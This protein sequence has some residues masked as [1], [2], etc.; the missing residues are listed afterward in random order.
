MRHE[1]RAYLIGPMSNVFAELLE[2]Y[3]SSAS[4]CDRD[5]QS[6][7]YHEEI[8]SVHDGYLLR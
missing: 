2:V 1:I 8:H 4:S 5:Q 7:H 6:V 3:Q